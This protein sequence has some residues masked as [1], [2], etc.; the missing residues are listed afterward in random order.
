[1][2]TR[3]VVAMAVLAA[4]AGVA[5]ADI[6]VVKIGVEVKP[7]KADGKAWDRGFGAAPRPD[8]QIT[9]L[10]DGKLVSTCT[11][12]PDTFVAD[13]TL[14]HPVVGAMR[15]SIEVIVDDEDLAIADRIGRA[16]GDTDHAGRL[17]LAVDGQLVRAWAE[18]IDVPG[19]GPWSAFAIGA[20]GIAALIGTLIAL[21]MFWLLRARWLTPGARRG[22]LQPAVVTGD[23]RFW[24]SP[25]LLASAAAAVIGVVIA[26]A[27]Y[28]SPPQ[29]AAVPYAFGAFA[30]TGPIIDAWAHEKA[31]KTR[32][33]VVFAGVAA[34][35]ALPVFAF[36]GSLGGFGGFVKMLAMT[37]VALPIVVAM[38]GTIL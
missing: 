26:N 22:V 7:T 29:A 27:V 25:V 14:E 32:L 28:T 17:E 12:V 15:V 24:R 6:E 37:V 34:C 16:V 33:L 11:A 3:V 20:R 31:G 23:V 4:I 8:P 10:E 18:V 21:A 13:C 2:L 30:V 19:K 38:L 9:V 1:M 36:F 35:A 5:R